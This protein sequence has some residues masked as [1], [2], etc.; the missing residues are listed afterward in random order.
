VSRRRVSALA[1]RLGDDPRRRGLGLLAR[2]PTALLGRLAW[3]IERA[4]RRG[5][6]A[7]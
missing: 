6:A 2:A 4:T 7:G 3:R 1:G 5:G